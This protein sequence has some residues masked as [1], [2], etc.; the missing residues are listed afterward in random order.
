MKSNR[1]HEYL[2]GLLGEF[3]RLPHETGWVEFKENDAEPQDIGEYISALA[4]S[5]ALEGKVSAYLIWGVRDEDHDIVGTS[6]DPHSARK[7]NEELENWLLRLLEPKIEFRFVP[8]IVEEKK[9]VIL[10]ISRAFRHPVRFSGQEFVRIG[11][12]KKKLK[13]F[14]EKERALWRTFD[15]IPFEEG[16]ARERA[17]ADEV[18]RLLDYPGY[19]DL[20]EHPLPA[21]RDG[22]LEALAADRMINPCD[23]GG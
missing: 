7:G 9:V 13:D 20:L 21:N 10:E 12:Y 16:I 5:A 6:F 14:P 11:S 3:C 8:I 4:N 2:V 22:I 23:A 1:D 18:L 15:Q 19:F 17:T